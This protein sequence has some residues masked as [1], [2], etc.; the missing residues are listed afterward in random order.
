MADDRPLAMTFDSAAERYQQARPDYPDSL[1]DSLVDLADLSPGDRLL[2]IGCATGKATIPLARRGFAITCVDPGP[3]LVEVARRNLAAYPDVDV[4]HGRF[5]DVVPD[6]TAYDLVLAATSWH[7]LDPEIRYRRAWELL[8]PGG[9]LA[10]WSATHVFPEGGDPIFRELQDVYD[11]IGEGVPGG[12]AYARPDELPD[13]RDEIEASGLF[14]DLQV[15][16]VDWEV[17]YDAEG[18]LALLDTFS[19]HIAMEPWQ[20]ERLYGEIRRR[21]A[22][23]PDGLLRRGWGAVLHVARRRHV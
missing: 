1:F 10:F 13:Q 18:Y 22:E 8:R 7:W 2:E 12:A 14:D 21:L 3:A 19:G 23:R 5:E 11:E 4:R 16:H 17:D 15:R 9:H 20:R 6:G